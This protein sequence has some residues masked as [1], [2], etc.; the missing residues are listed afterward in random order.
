MCLGIASWNLLA[1]AHWHHL[2]KAR[3]YDIQAKKYIKLLQVINFLQTEDLCIINL[4]A[5]SCS[6]NPSLRRTRKINN[7]FT[8]NIFLQAG[9]L[10]LSYSRSIT[11]GHH[12]SAWLNKLKRELNMFIWW[13]AGVKFDW[14]IIC[15]KSLWPKFIECQLF[16]CLPFL[17]LQSLL[18]LWFLPLLLP[19]ELL[20][21]HLLFSVA[22]SA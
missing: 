4:Q 16:S 5:K 15:A 2:L 6:N 1:Y 12:F 22:V 17:F 7:S 21:F 14:I 9:L 19:L 18:Q 11:V 8:S 13:E 20:Y 10:S 3:S